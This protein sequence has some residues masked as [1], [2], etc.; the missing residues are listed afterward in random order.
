MLS[1]QFA[2]VHMDTCSNLEV[3]EPWIKRVIWQS[4][5]QIILHLIN[6]VYIIINIHVDL[7]TNFH[8]IFSLL[9]LLMGQVINLSQCEGGAGGGGGMTNCQSSSLTH[10]TFHFTIR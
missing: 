5:Y 10:Y 6:Y 7:E 3:Q 4:N 1:I 8:D 2:N 9:L